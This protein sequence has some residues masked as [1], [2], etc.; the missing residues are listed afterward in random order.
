MPISPNIPLIGDVR[1]VGLMGAV[2]LVADKA[3]RR[4]FAKQTKVKDFVRARAQEHG[5]IVRTSLSSDS[6]AFSPPL[7][8]SREEIEEMLARFRIALDEAAT[9]VDDN[10]LR[11]VQ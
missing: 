3:S 5:L 6:L 2:E 7:I 9:W 4:R 10:D 1:S 11:A 8:I